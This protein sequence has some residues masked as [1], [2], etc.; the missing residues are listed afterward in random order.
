MT[1]VWPSQEE[2]E[3]LFL[4]EIDWR[5]SPIEP[6]GGAELSAE[7]SSRFVHLPGLC[8]Q[9]QLTRRV[10]DLTGLTIEL[11]LETEPGLDVEWMCRLTGRWVNQGT[12]L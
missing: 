3:A 10:L 5:G 2:H 6:R 9:Q 12:H 7:H 8:A 1:V 4:L 11:E